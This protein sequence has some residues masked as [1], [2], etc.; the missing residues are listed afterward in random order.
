V[1]SVAVATGPTPPERL[2]E[3]RPDVFF[4]DFSDVESTIREILR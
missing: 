2:L 1:R 4:R 3:E